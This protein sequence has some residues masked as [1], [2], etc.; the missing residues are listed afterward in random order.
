MNLLTVWNI[1]FPNDYRYVPNVVT[2]IPLPFSECYKPNYTYHRV[3]TIKDILVFGNYDGC[4][5][6]A[7]YAY[8]TKHM[9]SAPFSS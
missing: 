6:E 9:C 8:P 1:C 5:I 3:F 2:S 4:H 7:G